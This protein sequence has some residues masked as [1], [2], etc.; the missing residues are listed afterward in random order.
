MPEDRYIIDQGCAVALATDF[1]PGSCY[2]ESIPLI[3]V[4]ATLYMNI[5]IEEAVTALTINGAASIDR[6]GQYRKHRCG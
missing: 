3:F 5:T 4:L 6:A 1:N 2:T